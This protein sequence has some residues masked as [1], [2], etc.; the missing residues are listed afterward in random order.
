MESKLEDVLQS[1]GV[2]PSTASQLVA[3]GW[4][5]ATFACSAV[6][7]QDFDKS[8]DEMLPGH[9][10]TILERSQLRAAFKMCSTQANVKESPSDDP[11][12]A[13][14]PST[15]SGSW[16]EAFA[17]KLD[18]QVIQQLKQQYLKNY[19]SEILDRSTMPSTRLLSLVYHQI[20]KGQWAWVPWKF[21]MS[22]EK[23]EELQ[24][25]RASKQP[26]IEG[27]ALHSL[28][29]DEPPALD[30]SN[31]GM[32]LNTIRS[33]MELHNV[34]VAMCRGAHL[35]TLKQYSLRFMHYLTQKVDLDTGLRTANVVEAHAADRQIW[36][37]ISELLNDRNWNMDDALHEVT[38][39]RQ[40]MAGLL[41]FRPKMNKPQP[42]TTS[43]PSSRLS[44]SPK[45]KGKSTHPKGKGK[46]KGKV[47]W[48]T[49]I[50]NS[51]GSVKP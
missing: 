39:V 33:L 5:V 28:L 4:T 14:A 44:S 29:M 18:H 26:R 3:D 27:L 46:Q 11:M 21:R 50:R 20:Q 36:G 10:L 15:S 31:T 30:V 23:A 45:G 9:T 41:Q 19:P 32:G 40:D 35:A 42:W 7:I 2:D 48:V 38:H 16:S 43:A 17:P 24:S 49:E 51:D 6:D 22:A 47:H 25:L 34:A 37:F 8:L 1:A 13:Q 12:S